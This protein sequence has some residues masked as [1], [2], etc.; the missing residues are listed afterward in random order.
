M[1]HLT[2]ELTDAQCFALD[3]V[4]V[5]RQDWA[6]NVLT[7]RARRA[8]DALKE[9]PAWAQAVAAWAG[10]GGDPA[11]DWAVLLKGRDLGVFTT[12]AQRAATAQ[13]AQATGVA[14]ADTLAATPDLVDQEVV[15]RKQALVG[16]T[17]APDLAGRVAKATREAVQLLRVRLDRSWTAEEAARAA[18]LEGLEEALDRLDAVGE[19]LKAD[20]AAGVLTRAAAVLSDP[21]WPDP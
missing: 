18:W 9:E 5:D 16:A 6:D 11:D 17:T 8:R 14:V 21:R 2:I 7:D 3:T 19:A 15:R 10:D 1:P 12:A 4:A 13:A 20:I